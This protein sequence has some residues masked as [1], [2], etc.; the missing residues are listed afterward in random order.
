M[1][2]SEAQGFPWVTYLT[3]YGGVGKGKLVDGLV[4]KSSGNG[5]YMKVEQLVG[6]LEDGGGG[7]REALRGR[8]AEVAER[9]ESL[10]KES[11]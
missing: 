6:Y 5:Y 11:K 10:V 8:R 9:I 2:A 3:T 7:Y 1:K 4:L